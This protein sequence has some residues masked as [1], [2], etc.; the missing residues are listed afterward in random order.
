MHCTSKWH[1]SKQFMFQNAYNEGFLL[2]VKGNMKANS[3]KCIEVLV[4]MDNCQVYIWAN[5]TNFQTHG[6]LEIC[7]RK[8]YILTKTMTQMVEYV[9]WPLSHIKP[10]VQMMIFD[11]SL[12]PSNIN[13]AIMFFPFDKLCDKIY[14]THNSLCS[15][16]RFIAPLLLA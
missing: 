7:L 12:L 6:Y 10:V 11:W 16:I 1:Y 4:D 3:Q 13:V 8:S 14:C 15:S 9:S 5:L 2:L